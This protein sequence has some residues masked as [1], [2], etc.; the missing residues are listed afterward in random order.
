MAYLMK[1]YP[2]LYIPSIPYNRSNRKFRRLANKMLSYKTSYTDETIYRI[3]S[4]M[5]ELFYRYTP[6]YILW[7]G[8][9]HYYVDHDLEQSLVNDLRS[10][11]QF[12]L[13]KITLI[14]SRSAIHSNMA[15]Y[16]KKTKIM[17]RF[18][19][20]GL[21]NILDGDELD[22]MLKGI[23]EK[24]YGDIKYLRPEDY[25]TCST[26]QLTTADDNELN[27]NLGDPYG[28]CLAWSIW[29]IETRLRYP[30]ADDRTLYRN[31]IDRKKVNM[32]V[33]RNDPTIRSKNYYLD[34]IRNYANDL[35]EI[36]NKLL[37]KMRV[38]ENEHYML[39]PS[40]NTLKLIKNIFVKNDFL[41][42]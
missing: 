17:R 13:I 7:G 40:T 18:E 10:D 30:D 1:T 3:I 2:K 42:D 4:Q 31:A 16:C 6:H 33:G 15:L 35:D 14:I 11:T 5:N 27:K 23:F 8:R 28:Y 38:P 22:Q 19:P 41:A 29:F 9:D 20:A 36:K 37:R 21:N 32:M 24:V 12:V 39:Y 25:M 26:F 34:Y